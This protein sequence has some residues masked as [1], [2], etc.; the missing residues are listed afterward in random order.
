MLLLLSIVAAEEY[1]P[2]EQR[3]FN[4]TVNE[5][6]Y[7]FMRNLNLISLLIS[8][9]I[10][11]GAILGIWSGYEELQKIKESK[12]FRFRIIDINDDKRD[13]TKQKQ[14]LTRDDEKNKN[15]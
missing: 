5:E 3:F 8:F 7:K 4:D 1:V 6:V 10:I 11:I 12:F 13:I 2:V 9:T 15:D 14:S